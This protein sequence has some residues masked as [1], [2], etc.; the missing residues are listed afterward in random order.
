MRQLPGLMFSNQTRND[1]AQVVLKEL[2]ARLER[3]K[4]A[5]A[6]G[7]FGDGG[8]GKMKDSHI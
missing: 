6:T 1:T 2:D 7:R 3:I 8:G 5:I 4:T